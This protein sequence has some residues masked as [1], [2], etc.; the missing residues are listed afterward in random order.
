MPQD[1]GQEILVFPELGGVCG[2]GIC[3]RLCFVNF[4]NVWV[5]DTNVVQRKK[6]LFSL[7]MYRFCLELVIYRL[8]KSWRGRDN[9]CLWWEAYCVMQVSFP[10]W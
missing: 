8:T 7:S 1:V 10:C 9:A 2:G 3:L 5:V 6:G 4:A